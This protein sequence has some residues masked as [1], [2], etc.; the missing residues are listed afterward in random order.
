MRRLKLA[1]KAISPVRFED[2]VG[3]PA[4]VIAWRDEIGEYIDRNEVLVEPEAMRLTDIERMESLDG[5][6][7][8]REVHRCLAVNSRTRRMVASERNAVAQAIRTSHPVVWIG[9]TIAVAKAM[10]LP[11][12]SF[13]AFD[14]GN[15][16]LWLFPDSGLRRDGFV[17]GFYAAL[18]RPTESGLR[19]D[20][21][22]RGVTSVH[23]SEGEELRDED[24]VHGIVRLL[25]FFRSPYIPRRSGHVRGA[26]RRT[27]ERSGPTPPRVAFIELRR[28]AP[29]QAS[30]KRIGPV[31]WSY[32]WLVSGHLRRQWYPSEEKHRVIYVPPHVK[33]PGDKP[34]KQSA[35]RVS[36]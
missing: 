32:R 15:T 28:S 5:D 26:D 24:D 10:K 3:T 16:L 11:P 14:V 31:E 29:H 7:L 21:L 13:S 30:E 4:K 25:A 33:G 8:T 35:S 1:L 23:F 2:E 12:S 36:R 20:L 6:A 18:L 9:E 34:L 22:N 19:V 27:I 17:D